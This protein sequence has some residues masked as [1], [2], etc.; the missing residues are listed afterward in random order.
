M[1]SEIFL[2]L[3]RFSFWAGYPCENPLC[4]DNVMRMK[5]FM[6]N[7]DSLCFSMMYFLDVSKDVH[8]DDWVVVIISHGFKNFLKII[9]KNAF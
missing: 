5:F 2:S 7:Q 3:V 9:K 1:I 8:Y 4:P 6:Q